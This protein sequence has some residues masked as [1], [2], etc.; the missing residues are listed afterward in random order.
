MVAQL[1]YWRE[2]L[3]EPLPVIELAESAD[4]HPIDDLRTARRM[5]GLPA[6]L[7]E[8]ARRFSH[9]E[10]GTLF[11]A[12]V[13]ALKTLLHGYLG[14]DDLRVDT[15]VANRNR[16]G[17][18]P[19][20]GPL[21]NTVILRTN[22]GG[23]PSPQEVLR[24]VRATTLAAF[25]HQDLP[26]EELALTLE[27]ER[28]RRPESLAR[29]MILLQNATLRPQARSE[30]ALALEEANPTMILPLVT[31]TTFDVI[32]ALVESSI[33]LVGTCIYKPHLFSAETVDRLLR[34][35]EGTVE[36]MVTQS[37]RPISAIHLS[38]MTNPE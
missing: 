23:D 31:A 19:L 13:A 17:T 33:G 11:M 14:Q 10:G 9:Q 16:P 27:A 25:E 35:F 36:Q 18:E 4:R 6:S 20:I 7:A 26:F 2:Q 8:A 38:G 5:W 28:D 22:L 32:F 3:R 29:I 21:V 30:G 15:N 1:A 24:R 34:D 12:L 37:E